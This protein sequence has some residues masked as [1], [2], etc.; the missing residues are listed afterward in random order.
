MTSETSQKPFSEK[1]NELRVPCKL[2]ISGR[3]TLV[4]VI[5]M[6]E[7]EELFRETEKELKARYAAALLIFAISRSFIAEL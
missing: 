4:T 5:L 3:S 1:L 6:S 7:V 2:Q